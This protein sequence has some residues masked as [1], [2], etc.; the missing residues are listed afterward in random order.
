MAKGKSRVRGEPELF[1]TRAVKGQVV[2][3]MPKPYFHKL[4]RRGWDPGFFVEAQADD[5]P[6]LAT[7]LIGAFGA[8]KEVPVDPAAKSDPTKVVIDAGDFLERRRC[9]V[10]SKG[11]DDTNRRIVAQ[12]S[13]GWVVG[14]WISM[15]RR[16]LKKGNIN[17]QSWC[18][19]VLIDL[20][21]ID[22]F[23]HRQHE[24]WI[25]TLIQKEQP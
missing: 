9:V 13:D 11:P 8:Q 10:L 7:R 4:L 19:S 23:F 6:T 16:Q 3:R 24:E 2:T 22:S 18:F 14:L 25:A 5:Y 15:L 1:D 17:V 12:D 20:E 21:N